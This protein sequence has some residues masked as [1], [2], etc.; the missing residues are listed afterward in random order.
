[1]KL[2]YEKYEVPDF[3]KKVIPANFMQGYEVN[4]VDLTYSGKLEI[5]MLPVVELTSEEEIK[6]IIATAKEEGSNGAQG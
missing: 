5:E 1:M 2:I 6:A 4:A 3:L